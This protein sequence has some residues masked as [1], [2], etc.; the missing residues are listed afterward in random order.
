MDHG[1]IPD[2][3]REGE[4]RIRLSELV[5]SLSLVGDMGL[6]KP[7]EHALRTCILAL[8]LGEA[9]GLSDADLR[10]LYYVALLRV[11]GCTA[12]AHVA[13]ALFGD[14]IAFAERCSTLDGRPFEVIALMA[15]SVGHGH[16]P[17]KRI[18]M[19]ARFLAS[20]MSELKG[21]VR[22]SCEVAQVIADQLGF[23]AQAH[24]ALGQVFE[25]WDGHGW[26]NAT[27]GEDQ[28]ILARIVQLAQDWET[29]RAIGGPDVANEVARNRSGHNYD[30]AIVASLERLADD[31][32]AVL[33]AESVW[34]AVLAMEPGP[35]EHLAGE[36]LDEAL[37][38]F[39]DFT[40]LKSLF[41]LGHSRGVASLAGAAARRFGLG[42]Q[43]IDLV[44]RGA[45]VHDLGRVAVPA[46]VWE[47][48][49]PL[50][51]GDWER[52]RL[53]PYHTERTLA[54]SEGLRR[55]G[56]VGQA[57]HERLDGTGYH[58]GSTA[59]QLSKPAR[60][61][62][63]ADVYHAMT[64]PRPHREAHSPDVAADHLREQARTGKLDPDAVSAILAEAGHRPLARS[65]RPAG[66]SRRETEVLGLLCR[67][68]ANRAIADALFVSAKT[69][70]THVQHVYEKLGVSTRAA[71]AMFAMRNG[72]IGDVP[73]IA[74]IR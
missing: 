59:S 22:A 14:E 34:D 27:K 28:S 11:A 70:D 24:T 72:L 45:L 13:A 39:A 41:T 17:T 57:H 62:A 18:R 37:G 73:D 65:D 46:S 29:F 7:W 48:Q 68:M 67:G 31:E 33:E 61:V 47:K 9:S 1:P 52:V 3:Q 38:A 60:L 35:P 42:P 44:R 64:E 74:T 4:P 19:V 2:E 5:G 15:R 58:R 30:P 8:R 66:L 71:A 54:R 6:G 56:E 55:I 50:S 12:D 23:G 26:P 25:R 36:R 53:H 51:A 32:L 49:G 10:D 63:A 16:P 40:D 69:V 20:G 21:S 43:E